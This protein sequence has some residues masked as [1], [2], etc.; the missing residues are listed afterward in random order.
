[1]NIVYILRAARSRFQASG[2]GGTKIRPWSSLGY[3]ASLRFRNRYF[4]S[5]SWLLPSWFVAPS[6]VVKL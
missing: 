2:P 6:Y 3:M 5:P 4:F 1:V